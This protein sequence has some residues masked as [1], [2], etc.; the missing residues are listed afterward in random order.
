MGFFTIFVP[1]GLSKSDY[2]RALKCGPTFISTRRRNHP[3]LLTSAG[4]SHVKEIDL[5]PQFLITTRGWHD[6]R[7]R[8][9]AE[10]I[11]AEGKEAFA[12]RQL[13]GELQMEGIEAGLLR[14]ALF[15][16]S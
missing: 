11:A 7:E 16:C 8:F 15:V 4:F 12:E 13:D 14:R 9:R 5:T 6:G 1:D 10:L 2:A 3:D